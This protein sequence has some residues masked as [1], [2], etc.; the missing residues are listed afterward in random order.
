MTE[1]TVIA[2]FDAVVASQPRK[3]CIYWGGDRFTNADLAGHIQRYGAQLQAG[4]GVGR[5]DRVG[6][7]LKNCPEFIFAL[8]AVLKSGATVVPINNFLKAPEIQHI[9]DDCQL[10]CLITSADFDET[11]AKLTGITAIPLPE[12]ER[13]APA[14]APTWPM[15]APDDLAVIIYTSGTTGKSKGAMLTHGNIAS[16]VRSCIKALEQTDDDRLTLLLPMFHS[17][18][19][20]V[21]IFTP[22]SMGASIV[23]IKSLQPFKAAMR[24]II[25]N[26]AT[27]LVG[28][29]QLFQALADAKIPFW[30]HWL[31]KLRLAVSG[32]APLP[33]ETLGKFDRKFHFPLLEGYGLSEASPVV[34]FNPI[35]GVQKPGSVGLPLSDIEVTIVDDQGRELPHGQVG[36]IAVRGPNVMR[37]YYNHPEETAAALRDNWLHTGDMGKKDEDGYIYIVDRRKEMLLVRGMNV[38]PRE[39]EEVLHQFPN[40]REAAVV[41][42]PDEKRGEVPIAFVSAVNGAKLDPNEILRFCRDRLAD[43]KIPREV[44]VMETLPR[45]ATGKIAK[46][47][48]KK[49]L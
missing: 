39:I 21:C 6:I 23:L 4:H 25:R 9:V 15:L 1:S 49:G 22:L 43:Y 16:N 30:L 24:E 17:F 27:I 37:G 40:V 36:E 42:K 34:S 44:R 31:L 48:L 18:M 41:A 7:L 19:L 26:R 3:V 11:I 29:P 12:L 38:Y 13:G 32:A 35:R 20:T 46:L 28:I 5:G 2:Q 45:T 8:Y 14:S 33:G 10:K 47:E